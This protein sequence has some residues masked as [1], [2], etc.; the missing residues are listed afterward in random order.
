MQ[1]D[2]CWLLTILQTTTEK[3]LVLKMTTLSWDAVSLEMFRETAALKI[4]VDVWSSHLLLS[5]F[6]F[7]IDYFSSIFHSIIRRLNFVSLA[8]HDILDIVVFLFVHQLSFILVYLLQNVCVYSMLCPKK[9]TIHLQACISNLSTRFLVLASR[10][11]LSHPY[12]TQ[13]QSNLDLSLRLMLSLKTFSC[14]EFS[15]VVHV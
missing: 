7:P 2:V 13:Q 5:Y 14:L 3:R 4:S 15:R 9:L 1:F 8:S 11:Q 10:F 12:R 6:C